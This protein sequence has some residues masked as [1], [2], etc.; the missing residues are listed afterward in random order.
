LERATGCRTKGDART[1]AQDIIDET[2]RPALPAEPTQASWEAT[3]TDLVQTPDLRPDSIRGY[4]TA[5]KA[6]RT[7]SPN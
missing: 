4:R 5:V 1:K 6:L 7:M 3:L 2:Y